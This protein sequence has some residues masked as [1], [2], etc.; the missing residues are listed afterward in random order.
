MSKNLR[1]EV[2][3]DLPQSGGITD[4]IDGTIYS[5]YNITSDELDI[6]CNDS[7]D[8]ELSDFI[9]GMGKMGDKP[10]YSQI[11]KGIE[12]RNKYIDYYKK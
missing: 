9:D 10:T 8:E 6:I 4:L 11:R 12:I 7:T 1:K 3:E 5:F 2:I